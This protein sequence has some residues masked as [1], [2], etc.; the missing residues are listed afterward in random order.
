MTRVLVNPLRLSDVEKKICRV[1]KDYCN[2]YNNVKVKPEEKLV[3]RIA[4]GWVRDKLLGLESDDIDIVVN[5]MT[6]ETFVTGLLE[7]FN[8]QGQ[9]SNAK[10]YKIKKNPEKSKHLATCSTKL[11]DIS[12]DFV[13][14][15]SEEYSDH[16]RVPVAE[17]GTPLQD[18][19]RRDATLNALFYNIIENQVEDLSGR[20]LKDL[21]DGFLRTPMP[22]RQTFLDDP[23]RILRLIRFAS[24]FQFVIDPEAIEAAKQPDILTSFEKKVSRPRIG[25]E[26]H[27]ILSG[28]DPLYGIRLMHQVDLI[29]KIFSYDGK[30]DGTVIERS[31]DMNAFIPLLL[32]Q[33]KPLLRDFEGLAAKYSSP[34]FRECYL[35]SMI[36]SPLYGIQVD[37]GKLSLTEKILKDGLHFGNAVADV[38][39]VAVDSIPRYDKMVENYAEWTR[40]QIGSVLRTLKEHRELCHYVALTY[41]YLIETDENSKKLSLDMY[42]KF[43]EYVREAELQNVYKLVPLMNG[44]ELIQLY[45]TK[46]GVWMSKAMSDI[47]NWQMDHPNGTKEEL[48]SWLLEVKS[49]YVPV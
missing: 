32:N 43:E 15:R 8:K 23:L 39:K 24:R 13:N 49:N 41:R 37:S 18:V 30:L 7:Y 20:G 40:A 35:L 21:E 42:Q 2:Y 46:S 1:I 9:L 10:V 47:I 4:G 34:N 6:G 5:N 28:P 45:A 25:T 17:F 48:K 12:I 29:K 27:K 36:L 38:I 19:T 16:S 14:L 11:F 33:L 22:P 26:V 3:A 31:K 44:K